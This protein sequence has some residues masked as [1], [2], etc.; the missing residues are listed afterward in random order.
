MIKPFKNIGLF[1]ILI[2]ITPILFFIAKEI[3]SLSENEAVL[4]RIYKNQMETLLF[5]VNQYSEDLV[6]SWGMKLEIG[7][8]KI[9]ESNQEIS[10]KSKKIF[11]SNPAIRSV[12][13]ADTTMANLRLDYNAGKISKSLNHPEV[14]SVIENNQSLIRKL[15][16]YKKNNFTKF[17]PVNSLSS[18]QIQILL[19]MLGNKNICGMFIEKQKFVRENLSSK[20]QSI[21]LEEFIVSVYDSQNKKN[22]YST[23]NSIQKEFVQKGELWLIPSYSLG[24]SVPGK[25]LNDIL[26]NR[27]YS[28]IILISVLAIL[29]LFAARYGYKNI[30]QELELAQIKNEFVS[31]V[32]HELRTPLALINMFAETLYLGRVKS[33]EKRNE[34]YGI[35]QQETERLSKIVNTILNFSKI[36]AGKWKY[37]F[38][39]QDLNELTGK[40]FLNY[41]FHLENKG[42]EFNFI[43]DDKILE[44]DLDAEAISE[45]LVNLIDN[46][47]KYSD[48]IKCIEIRTGGDLNSVFV[49]VEDKGIGISND[50]Q[51]RIFEKFYRA[52]SGNIHNTKGTGLGLTLVK[53]IMDA[54][55]GKINLTSVLNKGSIFRLSIPVNKKN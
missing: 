25:N 26:R 44:A 46:A 9:S 5:S 24:I 39:V 14:R 6:R 11:E 20:L 19:F 3:Y 29:V 31:N 42:F 34:Y 52:Q 33:D 47:V 51:R 7:D 27:T 8:D 49:E 4:E 13:F 21:S 16:A 2:I 28:G 54:H 32:S 18:P 36:E 38:S 55:K 35:I 50:D 48:E 12:F 17:E 37:N 23:S 45:A 10:N 22:I 30:K 15:R 53:H 43:P 41:K 1:F 40:I